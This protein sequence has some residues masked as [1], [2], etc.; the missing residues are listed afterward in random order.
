MGQSKI[1]KALIKK[2]LKKSLPV[3]QSTH[4]NTWIL[5][6]ILEEHMRV[7]HCTMV[8]KG[9]GPGLRWPGFQSHVC[10]Y[11]FKALSVFEAQFLLEN[12]NNKCT[13]DSCYEGE[14]RYCMPSA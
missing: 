13:L 8:L 3:V 6:H 1:F 7:L 2:Y 10:P 5:R 12:G 9:G 11:L 14:I 4:P